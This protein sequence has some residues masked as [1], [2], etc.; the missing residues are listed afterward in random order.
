[1]PAGSRGWAS[2]PAQARKLG[3]QLLGRFS[4]VLC[5]LQ[6]V[7]PLDDHAVEFLELVYVRALSCQSSRHVVHLASG[8]NFKMGKCYLGVGAVSALRSARQALGRAPSSISPPTQRPGEAGPGLTLP[9][10]TTSWGQPACPWGQPVGTWGSL[11][12]RGRGV[13]LGPLCR[14]AAQCCREH[15]G[16]GLSGP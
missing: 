12:D 16:A 8:L 2:G 14:L 7:E 4:L 6:L 1:M 5:R 13:C 3:A 10:G 15:M 11:C 9:P